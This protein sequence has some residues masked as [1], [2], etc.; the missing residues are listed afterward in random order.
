MSGNREGVAAGEKKLVDRNRDRRPR[1]QA[2]L[3]WQRSAFERESGIER[4]PEGV[5]G[6]MCVLRQRTGRDR[7]R[8][9][10]AW[11]GEDYWIE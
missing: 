10:E 1:P 6:V 9:R 8:R 11:G 3:R 7:R 5:M 2:I 4:A